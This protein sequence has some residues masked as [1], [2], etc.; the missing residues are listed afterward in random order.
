MTS[1]VCRV[2]GIDKPLSEFSYRKDN[3]KHR[4]NCK[5]CRAKQE[6]ASRYNVTV[7]EIDSLRLAQDSCCAICGTHSS[8]IPHKSFE[9]N[10][11]VIDHDHTT[12]EVRGLLCPTCNAGLGHFMDSEELLLK[13]AFYLNKRVKR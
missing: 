12:G 11:L 1:Q 2:C 6:A 13:A 4:T 7:G 5:L 10:P 3:Q 9:H 8:D